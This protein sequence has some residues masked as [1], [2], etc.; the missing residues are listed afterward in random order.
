MIS[1]EISIGYYLLTEIISQTTGIVKGGLNRY[2]NGD[3][4]YILLIKI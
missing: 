2:P 3:D 4:M 1:Y